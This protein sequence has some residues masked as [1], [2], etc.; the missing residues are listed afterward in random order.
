MAIQ[1]IV[2]ASPIL[3]I[4]LPPT[5]SAAVVICLAEPA[6]STI[7][8]AYAEFDADHVRFGFKR[9]TFAEWV[10]MVLLNECQGHVAPW[11]GEGR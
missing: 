3:N 5:D 11:P 10:E 4:V 7:R 8:R 6:A 2:A 9:L 1:H